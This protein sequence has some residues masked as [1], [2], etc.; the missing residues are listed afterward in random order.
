LNRSALILLFFSFSQVIFSQAQDIPLQPQFE[1]VSINPNDGQVTIHWKLSPSKDVKGYIIFENLEVGNYAIDTVLG[2]SITQFT[3]TYPK[4]LNQPVRFVIAALDSAGNRS[5]ETD[6]PHRT[7]FSKLTYDSCS[8]QIKITWNPYE[9]WGT[10]L[11]R[12]RVSRATSGLPGDISGAL[13][14]NDT[15]FLISNV[16]GGQNYC[17]YVVAES[18]DGKFVTSN[19]VC[20]Q[21]YADGLPNFINADKAVFLSNSLVELT[22]TLDPNSPS[23]NYQLT[24]SDSRDGDFLPIKQFKNVQGDQLVTIDTLKNHAPKYYKLEALNSCNFGVLG[25]NEATAMVPISSISVNEINLVWNAYQNWPQ[26]IKEYDIYRAI[27]SNGFQLLQTQSG[28][29]TTYTDNI[30]SL[31]GKQLSGNVCYYIEGVSNTGS[32]G[33]TFISRSSTVCVDI[34]S[35]IFI[36]EAFTPNDDGRND[37]FKPSFAFLPSDYKLMIFNRSGFKIF[38]SSDPFKGWNGKLSN[39]EKA[40]EG[41][42]VF[43]ITFTSGSGKTVDK[44]GNFS[45]IYP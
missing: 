8:A 16:K 28:A 25:S 41:V 26:D 31:I 5:L 22:F 44:K 29:T 6:P 10:N 19:M 4:V 40:P 11:V 18:N 9:G 13:T 24:A 3:F 32:T 17:Y 27:G 35:N 36:P 1:S 12:Y 2:P 43:F 21:T 42:Y 38:E 39:G 34:T 30:S 20:R 23:K 7:V 37:E 33:N 14:P 15:S 45:L